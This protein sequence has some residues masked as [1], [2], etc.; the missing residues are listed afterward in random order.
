[1][2]LS[3]WLTSRPGRFTP[4]HKP[5]YP[6]NRKLG[7]PQ[8]GFGR[9]TEEKNLLLLP[10]FV[11]GPSSLDRISTSVLRFGGRLKHFRSETYSMSC[12]E[13]T[14]AEPWDSYYSQLSPCNDTLNHPNSLYHEPQ[15]ALWNPNVVCRTHNGPPMVSVLPQQIET[16]PVILYLEDPY[17]YCPVSSG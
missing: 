10:G 6:L 7:G 12:E 9:F 3:A 13:S 4:V 11:P 5:R 1:M 8:K 17:Y 16:A 2:E 15:C 14:S